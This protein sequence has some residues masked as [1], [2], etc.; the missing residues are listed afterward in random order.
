MAKQVAT[1][2]QRRR[3]RSSDTRVARGRPRDTAVD[4]AIADATIALLLERGVEGFS[5]DAVAQRSGVGRPTIYRRHEDKHALVEH[6]VWQFCALQVEVAPAT[7]DPL[8]DVLD[9]LEG[10]IHALTQT[11]FGG[12][13]RTFIPYLHKS[14]RYGKLANAIGGK[15]RQALRPA[16]ERAQA[17]GQLRASVGLDLLADGVLGALYFRF[18]MGRPVDRA[19]AHRILMGLGGAD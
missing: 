14:D 6:C 18:L 17:H 3:S 7:K 10:T 13:F 12:L 1:D 15:R 16:L 9:M 8:T 19:Y 4:D 11:P 5:I 2:L